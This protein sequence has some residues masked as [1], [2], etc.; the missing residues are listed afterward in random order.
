MATLIGAITGL[1][2]AWDQIR[3]R[4][5][6]REPNK[7]P[8]KVVTVEGAHRCKDTGISLEAGMR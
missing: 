1:I 5:D 3:D 2:L 6:D 8:A 7:F 4:E